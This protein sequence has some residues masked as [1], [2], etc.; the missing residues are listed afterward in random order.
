MLFNLLDDVQHWR[1]RAEQARVLAE[2]M[3]DSLAREMML[4]IASNYDQIA[5][6]ASVPIPKFAHPCGNL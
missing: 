5:E 2:Q 3:N 1:N 4:R 6:Q